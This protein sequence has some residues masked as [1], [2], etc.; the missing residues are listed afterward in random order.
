[1]FETAINIL[2][3]IDADSVEVFDSFV[4]NSFRN[5]KR[6]LEVIEKNVAARAGPSF[7]SSAG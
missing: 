5:D 3:L 6:L 7:R 1:M 2:Y 4:A